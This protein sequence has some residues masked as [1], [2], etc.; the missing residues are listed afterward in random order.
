M[1]IVRSLGMSGAPMDCAGSKIAILAMARVVRDARSAN[2]FRSGCQRLSIPRPGSGRK[3]HNTQHP[4]LL[5]SLLVCGRCGR[6][7]VGT[8]SA[9]GGRYICARRYPRYVPGACTG[10]SLSATVIEAC[11]WD[12]V[13][14]LLS[15]PAVLRAQYEQGHG[16]PAVD[17]RTEQER[18]RLERKLAALDREVTRLVDAYQ[19]EVIELT[20]LAERRRRIEDH[21]RMLRERVREIAQ[22]RSERSAELRRFCRKVRF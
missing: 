10:R 18:V 21:G 20:E 7:R 1:T 3:R 15:N 5:R 12:H 4:Y 6:R 13:K 22:Q 16:D 17:V 14:A 19:A 8:W 2:G 11:I 9:Q